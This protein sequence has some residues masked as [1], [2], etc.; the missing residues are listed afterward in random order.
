MGG[1]RSFGLW[2]LQN[3]R[4]V[5]IKNRL[6]KTFKLLVSCDNLD[7]F[8]LVVPVKCVSVVMVREQQIEI[9]GAIRQLANRTSFLVVWMNRKGEV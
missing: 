4:W 9:Q 6:E 1:G 8:S 2:A 3:H 5:G 7:V